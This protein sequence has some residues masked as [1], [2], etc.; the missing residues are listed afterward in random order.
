MGARKSIASGALE[1]DVLYRAHADLVRRMLARRGIPVADLDDLCHD[2][3]LIAAD[4]LNESDPPSHFGLWLRAIAWRVA[5]SHRRRGL[6]KLEL[7]S[8]ATDQEFESHLP[9]PEANLQRTQHENLLRDALDALDLRHRN[10]AALHL[11]EE[12]TTSDIAF[13]LGCDRKTAAKRLSAA[14]RKIE[15]WVDERAKLSRA[16]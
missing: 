12:L 6:R 3:F 14:A 4:R 7:L 9:S 11:F 5:A 2:V 1:W 16:P 15:R 8:D 13:V 10:V